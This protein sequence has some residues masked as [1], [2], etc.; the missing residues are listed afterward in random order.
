MGG[1]ILLLALLSALGLHQS[2][3]PLNSMSTA[4][5]GNALM[6]GSP[7]EVRSDEWLRW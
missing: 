4:A 7:L 6:L 3:L 2:S 5:P 1:G